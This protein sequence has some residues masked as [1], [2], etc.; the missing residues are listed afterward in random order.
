M[1]HG[2]TNADGVRVDVSEVRA[3]AAGLG[4][5]VAGTERQWQRALGGL[6]FDAGAAG[7]GYRGRGDAVDAGY[8]RLRRVLEA[9]SDEATG[10]ADLLGRTADGYGY[11]LD[12]QVTALAE[13]DA[14]VRGP[15]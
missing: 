2:R 10:V 15:R 12:R 14:D 4:R 3:I 13:I 8:R 9:W 7:P 6:C 11:E 1:G 5:A